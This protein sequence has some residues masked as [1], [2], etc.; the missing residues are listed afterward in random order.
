MKKYNQFIV[1]AALA[2]ASCTEK[3]NVGGGSPE[4]PGVERTTLYAV[5]E[6]VQSKATVDNAGKTS[7]IEGDQVA[8]YTSAEKFETLTLET[9]VDGVAKFTG[10]IEGTFNTGDVAV[11]PASAAKSY[12]SDKLT[13]AYPDT[14]AYVAGALNTPMIA[15]V[16][17]AEDEPVSFSHLGGAMSMTFTN[18]PEWAVKFVFESADKAVTGDFEVAVDPGVSTVSAVEG[19]TNNKVSFTFAK[20]TKEMT[21]V[22]P[23]PL[24][25]YNKFSVWFEDA[26]GNEI[27]GSKVTV[28]E[29]GEINK[30][31]RKAM[32]D[33]PEK[34]YE[35]WFTVNWVFGD[36]EVA[37]PVFKSQVPAIDND[38]NVYVLSTGTQLY[39]LDAHG[40]KLWQFELSKWIGTSEDHFRN[41]PV[42]RRDGAAVYAFGGDKGTAALYGIGSDGTQKFMT[43]QAGFEGAWI[44]VWQGRVAIGLDN[45]IFAHAGGGRSLHCFDESGNRISYIA[46][47]DGSR[48]GDNDSGGD[49]TVLS[50]DG[51]AAIG[52]S[53]GMFGVNASNM[54]NPSETYKHSSNGYFTPYAFHMWRGGDYTY[55][56]HDAMAVVKYNGKSYF[57]R[58]GTKDKIN[59]SPYFTSTDKALEMDDTPLIMSNQNDSYRLWYHYKQDEGGVV[60][61]ESGEAIFTLKD[62]TSSQTSATPGIVAVYPQETTGA[63]G[64]ELVPNGRN[65]LYKF[66]SDADV[67]GSCAVDN[68]GYIHFIDD[69]ANYYV[70]SPDVVTHTCRLVARVNIFDLVKASGKLPDETLTSAAAWTSVKLGPDG[71]IY[72]NVNMYK[73]GTSYGTTVCMSFKGTTSPSLVSSWPQEQADPMN[74]GL[75]V[76]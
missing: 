52:S 12:A 17:T 56:D 18:V 73:S 6:D 68:N 40:R 43:T 8:V 10:S 45:K 61:G 47:A 20:S 39:K 55:G 58:V 69:K 51:G 35:P 64:A 74:S 72:L 32:V 28:D 46:N 3:E 1:L 65:Y 36:A 53:K 75:Q 71:K 49:G 23:L 15:T 50:L 22:V 19:T 29:D 27:D 38:G 41:S 48:I 4:A 62:R 24:G 57:A 5:M 54:E 67:S 2:V 59:P 16:A 25:T 26:E 11:Y 21:F 31:V 42:L 33:M 13:V 37:L 7:W 66:V 34:V 44:R 63:N 30:V 60:A 70:V 14:Y 76:R 9:M